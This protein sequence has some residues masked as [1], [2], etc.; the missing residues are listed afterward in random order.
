M[1]ESS[2]TGRIGIP[3]VGLECCAKMGGPRDTGVSLHGGA[4]PLPNEICTFAEAIT[5][6]GDG[7][8]GGT[9]ETRNTT[10]RTHTRTHTHTQTHKHANTHTHTYTPA[11]RNISLSKREPSRTWPKPLEIGH[12]RD[13]GGLGGVRT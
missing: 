2:L 6:S 12:P 10:I 5:G 4:P 8:V 1:V 7:W 13:P 9:R 11:R 3:Q